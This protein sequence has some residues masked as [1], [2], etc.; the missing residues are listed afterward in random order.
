MPSA[1]TI[2]EMVESDAP[3]VI[4]L[5]DGVFA[6]PTLHNHPER[7][8]R[9]KLAYQP[10]LLFVA[11]EEERVV[12]TVMG[13]YDGHRGWIYSLAVAPDTRRR[14]I[15]TALVHHAEDELRARNCGKVNLQIMA[16]NEDVVAFY[17]KLGYTVEP[18]ISMGK[19]L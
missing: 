11:V 19:V 15:G 3:Q 6:Y 18:R 17:E 8:I 16:D 10:E 9:D 2:R 1:I 5:W 7:A 4:K 14:G 13:G 12:G